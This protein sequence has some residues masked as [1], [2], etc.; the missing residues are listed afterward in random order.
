MR[1]VVEEYTCSQDYEI[2]FGSGF[3]EKRYSGPNRLTLDRITKQVDGA[4]S[5]Q[6]VLDFGCGSGRYILPLLKYPHL[7]FTAFDICDSALALLQKKLI[8][9]DAHQRVSIVSKDYATLTHHIDKVGKADLILLIFGV[10]SHIPHHENRLS[11]LR[12]LKELLNPINGR[13][14]VSVPNRFRR[15]KEN[16]KRS[17][18]DLRLKNSV[19]HGDITYSRV[20]HGERMRFFYHLYDTDELKKDLNATGFDVL[21]VE[22]ESLLPESWVTKNPAIE[23]VDHYLSPMTPARLGYGLIAVGRLK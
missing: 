18:T 12:Q 19:E 8:E 16:Q 1:Q 13:I 22:A 2:Y 4:G 7:R 15:F 9:C 11:L 14:I 6:H 10:L 23:R 5:K 21:S 3:Y 17:L 20:Y